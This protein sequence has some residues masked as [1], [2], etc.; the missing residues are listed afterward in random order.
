[1]HLQI[2]DTFQ[3]MML[4]VINGKGNLVKLHNLSCLSHVQK[5]LD[6][7]NLLEMWLRRA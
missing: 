5:F 4:K 7:F 6:F 1:M 3:F 2:K